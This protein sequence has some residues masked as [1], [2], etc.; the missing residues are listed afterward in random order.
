MT[1]STP[2]TFE[3]P[4]TGPAVGQDEWVA[5]HAERRFIRGGP[6][7]PMEERF[8][9]IP[10]WT[11][12]TLF[13]GVMCLLP[14][15]ASSGY[16]RRVAF[17]TVLYMMLALGL[18]VVVGWGG[19]LD[20]GFVAFY[21]LGAYSYALLDSNQF[22]LHLPAYVAIPVVVAIGAIAGF[23]LG[24]PSRRL[25]GDYL[26][27][28]TL[29]FLQLFQTIATNGDS[30]FGHNVTGGA[31]GIFTVKPLHAFGHNLPVEHGGVFAVSYYYVALGFFALIYVALRFVNLSRTGRAWRSLRED[32]LAAEAMG[33]PVNMLK[34]MAFSFGAAIAA[35]TGTLYA[36]LSASVL[37]LTFYFV[38][39]ITVYT[40]V[41][42]GGSGSQRGVVLGALVIG[43]LLELLRDPNKSRVIFYIALVGGLLVAFRLSRRLGLVVGA[44]LA[45]GFACHAIAGAIHHSWVAGERARRPPARRVVLGDHPAA[46]RRLDPAHDVHRRHLLRA[47]ADARARTAAAPVVAAGALPRRI[48]LG[49][50]DAHA[51]RPGALHRPRAHPHRAHDHPA[52]RPARRTEGRDRL[53]AEKLLEIKQVSLNFGGLAVV[54]DLD[55]DVNKGEI[56]SV[57]G[58]NGAGKTTLFNLITGIYRPDGGDI[59]LEGKSLVGLQPHQI[60]QRGVSRTFQTLRL[61]LNMSVMENVMAAE[62][63]HTH[64]GVFRS[65]LRTPGM[66]REEREIREFASERLAFFGERLMGYRWDQ[67]AYSLSYANRRRLEIARATATKPTLLLLDEPAAGMNPVETHE[68]AE[69]IGRLR[70]EGGYTILVIEHDMHVVE[71]ISDRVIALD[72]GVKIAEGTFDQ[73][74]TDP[75]VVEA[76]L[77]TKAAATK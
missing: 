57:I 33:M 9:A 21:G 34:L 7:A 61:F 14:A 70:E 8:R 56:V 68:I 76:Y 17:D 32:P 71:G 75:R 40:M 67:P 3:T 26:A 20:L 44:T 77:G 49:Q 12:L 45:F 59:L 73:V 62:Y 10:W 27:I 19:L 42:L 16:V 4:A 6:L 66:R 74:A 35:L 18:N 51:A 24:L 65:M 37:P 48:R 54:V 41:I 43:P 25:H 28:V 31:F 64:A 23:L 69:L 2:H 55:I 1:D 63:G 52:E 38:L 30:I 50:R 46:S 11:W 5:R 72:H 39:L 58:P 13:V 53:M 36:S 47:P 29:F 22:H 60:S 15:V